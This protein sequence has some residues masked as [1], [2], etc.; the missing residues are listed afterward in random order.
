MAAGCWM[1][2][3]GS[4]PGRGKRFFS[5]PQLPDR[6]LFPRGYSG[7]GAKLIIHLHQVPRSR[8]VEL[9][10]PSRYFFMAWYLETT[11]T[12]RRHSVQCPLAG[13][14][15]MA[16]ICRKWERSI[17]LKR[18]RF[19]GRYRSSVA[20]IVHLRDG[21]I[22]RPVESLELCRGARWVSFPVIS[23]QVMWLLNC[24]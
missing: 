1:D 10:L 16:F 17:R 13:S 15:V 19:R 14:P 20:R 9:C 6:G 7:R 21:V 24:S 3:R 23:H 22:I 12:Y 4:I 5:S 8:M 11:V 18:L 2:P